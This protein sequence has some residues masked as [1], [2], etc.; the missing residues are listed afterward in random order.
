MPNTRK[1]A[2]KVHAVFNGLIAVFLVASFRSETIA[3]CVVVGSAGAEAAAVAGALAGAL[4]VPGAVVATPAVGA[5]VAASCAYAALPA[6]S[7]GPMRDEARQP[8][9]QQEGQPQTEHLARKE[10]PAEAA[11]L[12]IPQAL[13][14]AGKLLRLAKV[15]SQIAQ[16]LSFIGSL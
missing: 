16:Y 2:T 3:G 8:D 13:G 11:P 1:P 6:I 14:E 15:L 10:C 5:V 4:V 7:L 9:H 12:R